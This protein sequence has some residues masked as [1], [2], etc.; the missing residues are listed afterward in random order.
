MT[1]NQSVP[2]N[3]RSGVKKG[4]APHPPSTKNGF[5]KGFGYGEFAKT[6]VGIGKDKKKG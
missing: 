6:K 4:A 5:D 1:W 2:S 3:K